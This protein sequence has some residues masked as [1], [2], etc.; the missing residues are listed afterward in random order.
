[1]TINNIRTLRSL[2]HTG[3]NTII[4]KRLFRAIE[5][6]RYNPMIHTFQ[7]QE[8]MEAWI[9]L[10]SGRIE[11]THAE[12]SRITRARRRFLKTES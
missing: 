11:A 7:F 9:A 1:M 2:K 3:I 6:G 10:K 8:D 4:K 12:L 5:S